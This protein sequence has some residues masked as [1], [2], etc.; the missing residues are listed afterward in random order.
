MKI[1]IK[2]KVPA[3]TYRGIEEWDVH[4]GITLKEVIDK[5]DLE[6]FF[7]LVNNVYQDESLPLSDGDVVT[8]LSEPSGG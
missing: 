1:Y 6:P 5:F 2:N 8:F 7:P 4:E 3:T